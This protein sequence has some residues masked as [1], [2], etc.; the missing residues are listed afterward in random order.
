VTPTALAPIV[1][2]VQNGGGARLFSDEDVI[3]NAGARKKI[4]LGVAPTLP[5]G[6]VGLLTGRTALALFHN[7]D[8]HN[9][10][11]NARIFSEAHLI[12]PTFLISL[13]EWIDHQMRGEL[14]VLLI[15][16]GSQPFH[17]R[18]HSE[19]CIMN[20]LKTSEI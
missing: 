10:E 4:R 12:D 11:L 9:G 7:V 1:S 15:N 6:V 20:F 5:H 19:I 18:I 14:R 16:N 17:V 2:S 8:V 3:V 13:A